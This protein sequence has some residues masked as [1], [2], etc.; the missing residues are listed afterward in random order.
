MIFLSGR[1]LVKICL[2]GVVCLATILVENAF[3]YQRFGDAYVGD[4]GRGVCFTLTEAEFLRAGAAPRLA[5]VSV[6]D[7]SVLPVKTIWSFIYVQGER[8]VLSPR[9]CGL[10]GVTPKGARTFREPEELTPG[11]LYGVFLN[12]D[13]PDPADPTR[14][15]SADFC[16]RRAMNGG[17]RVLMLPPGSVEGQKVPACEQ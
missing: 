3:A 2:V 4:V 16:I 11:K 10:Y 17:F 8:G 9:S 6:F 5:S 15:Y 14:G 12:A 1:F 7:K 13:L